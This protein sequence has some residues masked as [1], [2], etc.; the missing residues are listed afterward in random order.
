MKRLHDMHGYPI[1]IGEIVNIY[2]GGN[3]RSEQKHIGKVE[4]I[5]WE[6]TYGPMV[7]IKEMPMA[8]VSP[9]RIEKRFVLAFCS[10]N[11]NRK[12]RIK[13]GRA[14]YDSCIFSNKCKKIVLGRGKVKR[15]LPTSVI[16]E[17]L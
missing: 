4:G 9:K 14:I 16:V 13:G 5:D 8:P 11:A 15:Y 2:P 1:D 12:L 6:F 3:S 17:R 7:L 10:G